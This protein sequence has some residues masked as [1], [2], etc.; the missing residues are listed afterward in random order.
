MRILL[1]LLLL[2]TALFS[3]EIPAEKLNTLVGALTRLGPEKVNANPRLLE[4]LNKVLDATKGTGRFVEIVSA[5][6]LADRNDELLK[7]AIANPNN[8]VGVDSVK[9]LMSNKGTRLLK[10]ALK[11]ENEGEAISLIEAIGNT[12]SGSTIPI[13][14]VGLDDS[15]GR[16]EVRKA[17]VRSLA[18][19][20]QGAQALLDRAKSGEID[21]TIRLTAATE[22]N[23]VRW[24]D[25]R[26]QAA[27][28]VPLPKGREGTS[29]APIAELIKRSGD[30]KRGQ[31]VF[32]R[33]TV[34]CS[35]C[36]Q[37]NGVGIDFGPALSEI[38]TKLSA[39]A[40]YESILAPNAG[41]LMGYESWTVETKTGDEFY[42][43]LISDTDKTLTIKTVGGILNKVD[44]SAILRRSKSKL[45]TMPDGLQQLM[46]EQ[47]LID[48]VEYL[49]TLKKK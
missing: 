19:F 22:L 36:H 8:N 39:E 43:L 33:E 16:T 27:K 45:S 40:L 7:L 35:R 4:A 49:K 20:K 14:T 1:G 6:K 9:V 23:A 26:A 25:V 17:A 31:S 32:F 13:L 28:L 11:R 5:F 3:A 48:L 44:K 12:V 42:G 38:G 41:I 21:S 10:G 18:K 30:P 34:M 37:V 24:A 2:N 47:D 15:K 46:S 29:F